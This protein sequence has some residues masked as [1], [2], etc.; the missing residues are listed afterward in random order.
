MG[1]DWTGMRAPAYGPGERGGWPEYPPEA[2]SNC[3]EGALLGLLP[4]TS[5]IRGEIVCMAPGVG[6]GISWGSTAKGC[7]VCGG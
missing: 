2:S 4:I 1:L 6:G 7:G 3:C 5:P